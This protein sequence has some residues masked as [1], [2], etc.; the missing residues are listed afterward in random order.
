MIE[1]HLELVREVLPD[2]LEWQRSGPPTLP[3]AGDDLAREAGIGA[4]PGL[5]RLILE[6]QAA[7]FAGEIDGRDEVIEYARKVSA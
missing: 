3:L 7:L 5:G 6:V 1:A 2:A 4:G